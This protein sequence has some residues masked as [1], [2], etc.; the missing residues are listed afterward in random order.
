LFY[1]KITRLLNKNVFNSLNLNKILNIIQS[2]LNLIR[3]KNLLIL[4]ITQLLVRKFLADLPW[5]EL[6]TGNIDFRF[7]LLVLSTVLIAAAGY[8]I[9][10][11][12]DV[13]IDLI[14]KP[15]KV[16]IGR[17]LKRR[18]AL[19]LHQVLSGL[20]ILI[21]L[22]LGLKIFLINSFAVILLWFYASI[23]K[24]KPFVGNL[25]VAFL[26]GLVISELAIFYDKNAILIH[27]YAIF[28]FFI[29]L[30]REIVKD[31]ED[32]R[33]DK[34]HGAKTLPIL[35]GIRKSKYVIYFLS[36]LLSSLV[37]I[38]SL[39]LNNHKLWFIFSILGF[40]LLIFL[41]KLIFADR[42]KHFRELS[43]FSKLIMIL[44]IST[45]I[46]L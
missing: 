37:I 16:Y 21:G 13:K 26:T 24:K 38:L 6:Y 45:M 25:I 40:L 44:G 9:N 1:N 31:I 32:I 17:I 5:S 30:I 34:A 12:F 46:V 41:Y 7:Y 18:K 43:N 2:Y 14:N 3:W 15:D 28:A 36:F 23:F 4:V 10:D 22:Y 27:V 11:Y 39:K 33:G 8:L 42:K 19:L 29:N 35:I 20:G